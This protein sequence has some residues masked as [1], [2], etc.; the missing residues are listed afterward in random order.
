M[1]ID[2]NES[3]LIRM[4]SEVSIKDSEGNIRVFTK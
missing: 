4:E 2:D 3:E 1:Y